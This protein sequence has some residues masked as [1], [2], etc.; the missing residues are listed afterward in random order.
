MLR[1]FSGTA[2]RGNA[3]FS[4]LRRSGIINSA[5]LVGRRE[6][7][8]GSTR[9]CAVCP[10]SYTAFCCGRHDCLR[11]AIH[12]ELHLYVTMGTPFEFLCVQGVGGGKVPVCVVK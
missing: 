5:C 12:R 8:R 2:L 11:H 10:G 4:V 7:G 1:E 9:R 3:R 6:A